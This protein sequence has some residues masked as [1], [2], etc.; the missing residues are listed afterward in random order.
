M[1]EDNPTRIPT[2]LQP[3]QSEIEY[4]LKTA[5]G[6]IVSLRATIPED[7][8]TASI[9]GTERVGHGV[10]IGDSGLIV[11]I[12]YLVTE[13]DAIWLVS[14]SGQVATGHVVGYDYESGLGL[15][16]ALGTLDVPPMKIGSATMIQAGGEVVLAGYGGPDQSIKA[17][18]AAKR[19]FAGY[20]EY[21]L[22]EAVFTSPPHPNWGGTALISSCGHL[23]G[24]GSLYI[25]QVLTQPQRQSAD[26]NM[27]VPIDLLT[28]VMDELLSYG[29]TLKPAR[30]WLG[31]FVSDAESSLM[32]AGIYENAP[33][34]QADLRA[35]DVVLEVA[36]KPALSLAAFFRSIWALGP[37]G[38]EIPL[39][40]HRD[41]DTFEARV[42]SV[43]RR[44]FWR[45]PS[46]H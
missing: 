34:S 44:D 35:G 24:I 5:L 4:D 7:A 30:P 31:F 3:R 46:L 36:G 12:G 40:L 38:T 14:Q 16:Q 9:L 29:R 8:F 1:S 43:D 26:G 13:A 10:A 32:I 42:Q 41:G 33:A 20:W 25:D 2:E 27:S 15:V 17:S 39:T 21:V 45:S 19:E 18:V 11:T 37:A 28:P 22:E 6:A 23:C